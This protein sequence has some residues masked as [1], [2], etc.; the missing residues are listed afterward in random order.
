MLNRRF[1]D[2][3]L[4]PW[5]A[6]IALALGFTGFSV[7]LFYKT[8]LAAPVYVAIALALTG[9]FS[10]KRRYDFLNTCFGDSKLKKI[11]VAENLLAVLPFVAFLGYKQELLS[12]LALISGSILLALVNFRS[13]LNVTIPTPFYK[14]PFEFT[15]G[16]RSTL[17]L[18]VAAYALACIAVSVGNFNLGIFAML[19]LFVVSM[20]YYGRPENEYYVWIHSHSARQFLGEKIKTALLY[21]SGLALPIALLLALFFPQNLNAILLCFLLGWGFLVFIVVCK[22]AAYPDEMNIPQGVLLALCVGFPPLLVVLIPYLFRQSEN[23]LN[24]L[25]Q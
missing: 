21:A 7:Y 3:G 11:R 24:R 23:R 1:R 16:F 22:Y 25:F 5:L 13:T 20:S 18:I 6:Y 12:A 4:K 9:G 10:E 15:V 14:R 19:L 2:A 17:Y 8:D